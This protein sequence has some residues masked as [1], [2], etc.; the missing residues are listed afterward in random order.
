MKFVEET[1]NLEKKII[2]DLFSNVD[3]ICSDDHN[4]NNFI[5]NLRF[6]FIT[7]FCNFLFALI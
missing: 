7:R 1:V 5:K 2:M 4:K 6:S 3:R